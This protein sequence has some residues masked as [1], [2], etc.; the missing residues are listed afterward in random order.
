[1]TPLADSVLATV[2]RR[3][4]FRPGA[5]VLAAV[6]GGP[7]SVALVYLLD[8]L[9]RASRLHLVGLAHLDHGL[10]GSEAARDAGFCR[11]LA[12]SLG[13]PLEMGEAD[14]AAE[15]ATRRTSLEETARAVRYH[16][17]DG[18]RVRFGADVVAVGHTR[19]DQAETVLLRLLR[20]AGTRG[21][22]GIHP[23]AGTVVRPLLDISRRDVV[24]YLDSRG[25]SYVE[26]STNRDL[27]R[28]RNRIRHEVLPLLTAAF[29]PAVPAVLAREA[30]IARDDDAVLAGLAAEVASRTVQVRGG[31][32]AVAVGPLRREPPAIARRVVQS[33]IEG[34]GGPRP[35]LV[36]ME[37]VLGV[38]AAGRPASLDLPGCR[39]E[40]R[41]SDGVL[42]VRRR[43][44]GEESVPAS[45]AHHLPVPGRVEVP[46]A[47]L[48]CQ[49]VRQPFDHARASA[50]RAGGLTATF[51]GAEVGPALVIRA[52]QPGDRL[53]PLGLGGQKKV[54]DV[55]VDRKVPR[56]HRH[57]VPIVTDESGRI[58]WVAGHAVA[59]AVRV[60]PTTKSVVVLSFEPLGGPA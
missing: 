15:M 59:E 12:E 58:V 32:V 45:W 14:V 39:A 50:F 16:F 24:R 25:L 13:V 42:L 34:L 36:H 37:A 21:M 31:H 46:E 5:R 19:D 51:A 3:R 28:A 7:D 49:A 2:R 10:R 17:L 35:G 20:G 56:G 11:Q 33:V 6:S 40:L 52:W 57:R 26:D 8:E 38:L 41:P 23:R 47:G 1:M 53:R 9:D 27:A 18:A 44:A 48:A 4:L 30:D 43:S 60:T 22:A 29:G 54:Q 55:F